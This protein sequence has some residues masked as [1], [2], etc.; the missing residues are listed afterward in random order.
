ML[1]FADVDEDLAIDPADFKKKITQKTKAVIVVYFQWYP[2]RMDEI[3]EI[4][5]A[6]HIKVIEIV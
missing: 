3:M 2:A 1:V 5:K 4:A 6:N